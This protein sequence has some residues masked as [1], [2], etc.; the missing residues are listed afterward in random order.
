LVKDLV[1]GVTTNVG[2]DSSAVMTC[3]DRTLLLLASNAHDSG[4]ND[5]EAVLGHLACD[6]LAKLGLSR[7]GKGFQSLKRVLLQL[8]CLSGLLLYLLTEVFQSSLHWRYCG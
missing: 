7:Q 3:V 6:I 1:L 2:I 8:P 5:V 4:R